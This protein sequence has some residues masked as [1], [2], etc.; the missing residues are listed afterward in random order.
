MDLLLSIV[1][2]VLRISVPYA[3]VAV[4]GCFSE[5]SGVIN[6]ALEGILLNSAFGTAVGAIAT[7]SPEFGVLCGLL[8][9]AFT[10]VVHSLV[11]VVG[12]ADQIVSGLAINIASLGATRALLKAF[13]TSASN[14]PRILEDPLA[15]LPGFG[16]LGTLG[17]VVG[18][19]LFLFTVLVVIA[20]D[21]FLLRSGRGLDGTRCRRLLMTS[22]SR[23]VMG[24]DP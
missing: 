20:A 6:I 7:G 17:D 24:T 5:R 9:G 10:A 8:A 18:Q 22:P 19:P 11:T 21:R 3:L 15:P 13:Y 12:R 16:I 1:A 14:S 23:A 4:G 2:Q